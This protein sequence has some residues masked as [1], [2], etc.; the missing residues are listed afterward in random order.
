M[1]NGIDAGIKPMNIVVG[2]QP[3]QQQPQGQ[4]GLAGSTVQTKA[5]IP[6]IGKAQ[7]PTVGV[8]SGTFNIGDI[9]KQ[10][11]LS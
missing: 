1:N 5:G 4:Q 8:V 10:R 3:L 9:L 7:A 2:T 6:E 11:M